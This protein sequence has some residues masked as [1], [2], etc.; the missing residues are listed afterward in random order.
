M[1]G[2][3]SPVSLVGRTVCT[4]VI[5]P[6]SKAWGP[7]VFIVF[8]LTNQI[9]HILIFFLSF[10]FI[11]LLRSVAPLC[12]WSSGP[13]GSVNNRVNSEERQ[14]EEGESLFLWLPSS[15]TFPRWLRPLPSPSCNPAHR[16]HA[17]SP[18]LICV[19]FVFFSR[20]GLSGP[21][22]VAPSQRYLWHKK[23]RERKSS[24]ALE[25]WNLM[26]GWRVD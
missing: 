21:A 2:L 26:N 11:F 19:C 1:E 15:A 17:A 6:T 24:S 25:P 22:I 16:V 23:K 3:I 5:P 20:S 4:W 14:R 13:S 7:L 9:C 12:S 18:Q 10:L 8:S